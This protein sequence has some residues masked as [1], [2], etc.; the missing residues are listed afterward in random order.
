MSKII[1]IAGRR[2][3]TGKSVTAVNLTASLS[4]LEKKSLLIDCDSQ[5]NATAWSGI[6]NAADNMDLGALF[7]GKKEIKDVIQK[8]DLSYMDVLPSNINLYNVGLKLSKKS[9]NQKMLRIFL[10]DIENDYD[11]IIIDSPSA[12]GFLGLTAMA[13]SDWILAS[14]PCNTSFMNDLGDLLKMIKQ[15]RKMHDIP[16]KLAGILLNRCTLKKNQIDSFFDKKELKNV[17]DIVLKTVIPEDQSVELTVEFSKPV[18]L[19]DA[20]SIAAT[21]Y[22]TLAQ[23][24]I[25]GF[26]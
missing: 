2:D 10:K 26:N 20:K 11:Y 13:A 23:E 7:S 3:K 5:A 18:A 6:N 22:L 16:L 1:T 8:T 17:K 9:E 25:A 14:I 15:I 12:P 4:L 21:K 19:C 24:L